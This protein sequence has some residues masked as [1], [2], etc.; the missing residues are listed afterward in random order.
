MTIVVD[1][2]VTVI[3]SLLSIGAILAGGG[4]FLYEQ[5]QKARQVWIDRFARYESHGLEVKADNLRRCFKKYKSKEKVREIFVEALA[6]Q[7][8][9][10]AKAK[11]HFEQ[12]WQRHLGQVE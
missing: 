12:M 5:S 3:S 10:E 2:W 1:D 6:G 8:Y 11:D 7:L 9:S 4:W